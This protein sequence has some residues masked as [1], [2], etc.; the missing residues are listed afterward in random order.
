MALSSAAP[1]KPHYRSMWLND[2]PSE[3]TNP[4][5][6]FICKCIIVGCFFFN[7]NLYFGLLILYKYIIHIYC[8]TVAAHPHRFNRPH[9]LLHH[10]KMVSAVAACETV[11]Q[12]HS[13]P[14]PA[15]NHDS[16]KFSGTNSRQFPALNRPR[17]HTLWA[18]DVA[19]QNR[20]TFRFH[21]ARKTAK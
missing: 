15:G 6:I 14:I 16:L 18:T 13:D 21:C 10:R 11:R 1:T 20:I 2:I 12:C 4:F 17:R 8:S 7:Y 3:R 9:L 19:A 5:Q